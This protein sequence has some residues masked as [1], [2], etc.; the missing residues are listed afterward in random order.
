MSSELKQPLSEEIGEKQVVDYL[1]HHADFFQRHKDL[2]AEMS[3]SHQSG[4]AVSLIERQVQVL[5]EQ[6]QQLKNRLAALIHNAQY[7]EEL[8]RRLHELTLALLEAGDLEQLVALLRKRLLERFNADSVEIRLFHTASTGGGGWSPR[9]EEL[10]AAPE[11]LRGQLPRELLTELFGEG[12]DDIASAAV[13]P[14]GDGE[15]RLGVLAL[16]SYDPE[17]FHRHAGAMFLRS[18]G[19]ILTGVMK[20]H[21]SHEAD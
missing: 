18:L 4:A 3:L 21:L 12:V 1:R 14:L 19:E 10:F 17:R 5:R 9:F 13:I 11:P 20:L 6:R 2:L 7:N 8:S 15:R 16:G